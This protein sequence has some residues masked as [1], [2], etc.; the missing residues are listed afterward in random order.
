MSL[1]KFS[2]KDVLHNLKKNKL[3]KVFS[4]AQKFERQNFYIYI[5]ILF[6]RT[7]APKKHL[8]KLK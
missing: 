3:Q 5:N 4:S 1:P 7:E 2:I 6:K 8:E